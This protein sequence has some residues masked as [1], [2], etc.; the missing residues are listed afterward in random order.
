MNGGVPFTSA[1]ATN[2]TPH[3]NNAYYV[4]VI[5]YFQ[6]MHDY[7]LGDNDCFWKSERRGD[8]PI[9]YAYANYFWPFHLHFLIKHTAQEFLEIEK[10]NAE[11]NLGFD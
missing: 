4:Q 9:L 3:N 6:L 5:F 1:P 2:T 11:S 7:F 10:K 8:D